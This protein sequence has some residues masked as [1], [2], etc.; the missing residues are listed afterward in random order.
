MLECASATNFE[1][2]E[3]SRIATNSGEQ[4]P[5]KNDR[6]QDSPVPGMSFAN[7]FGRETAPGNI[8]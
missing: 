1:I 3:E 8:S 5:D 2:A 4:Q 6:Y 7:P